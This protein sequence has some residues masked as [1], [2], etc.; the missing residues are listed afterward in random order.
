MER[1][2]EKNNEENKRKRKKKERIIKEI[3]L[4]TKKRGEFLRASET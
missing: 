3:R 4:N 2:R 1:R